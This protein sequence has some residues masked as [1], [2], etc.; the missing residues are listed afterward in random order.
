M[1][2]FSLFL[3]YGLQNQLR[4]IENLKITSPKHHINITIISKCGKNATNWYGHMYLAIKA[5]T[6][7]LN[8]LDEDEVILFTNGLMSHVVSYNSTQSLRFKNHI[9]FAK[10]VWT[11]NWYITLFWTLI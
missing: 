9:S 1:I 11:S 5:V 4:S 6:K 7:K 2:H 10:L 3:G 8:D